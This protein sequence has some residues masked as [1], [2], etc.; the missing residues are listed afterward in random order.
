LIYATLSGYGFG[1]SFTEWPGNERN[2]QGM[3]G[4]SVL[5]TGQDAVCCGSDH[6]KYQQFE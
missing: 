1:N 3:S 4:V 6:A 5:T 2:A